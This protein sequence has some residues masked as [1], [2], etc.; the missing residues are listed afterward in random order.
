MASQQAIPLLLRVRELDPDNL[1]VGAEI[2]G[3]A[4]ASKEQTKLMPFEWTRR[5]MKAGKVLLILDGLDETDQEWRYLGIKKASSTRGM[6]N[7]K[8]ETH[9]CG[10][11]GHRSS[12]GSSCIDRQGE[13]FYHY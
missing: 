7:N 11:H 8:R 1:P 13:R 12:W 9:Q 3:K 5:Q 4:T 2:V 6:E 10:G